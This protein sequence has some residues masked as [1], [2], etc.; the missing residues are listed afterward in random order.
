VREAL[1]IRRDPGGAQHRAQLGAGQVA[2]AGEC[3]ADGRGGARD[4][5]VVDLQLAPAGGQTT[6]D[7]RAGQRK[8]PA[9]VLREH[10]MPGGPQDVRPQEHARVEEAV[11]LRRGGLP[12]AL[13]DCPPG[14]GVVLRLDRA[15]PAHHGDH[16]RAGRTGQ[17]LRAQA[18]GRDG[19]L[20]CRWHVTRSP[21]AQPR[22]PSSPTDPGRT[23]T[24]SYPGVSPV[25]VI[26][27]GGD[28]R[29]QW[30]VRMLHPWAGPGAGRSHQ[31]HCSVVAPEHQPGV[32]VVRA[33]SAPREPGAWTSMALAAWLC[34][35]LRS[36][37]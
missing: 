36:S 18:A 16:G 2:T 27:V 32:S 14:A 34:W 11:E 24:L 1:A 35:P 23:A 9:D 28:G 7:A 31:R 4:H 33:I 20:G 37:E 12:G 8:E 5:A 25:L 30:G 29:K 17:P 19:G 6:A 3:C 26:P 22:A 21:P 13:A 10:D 15:Q